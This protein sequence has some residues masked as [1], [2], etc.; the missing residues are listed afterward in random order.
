MLSRRK[1]FIC[2]VLK[3]IA[4]NNNIIVF[5][6]KAQIERMEMDIKALKS[7]NERVEALNEK[8]GGQTSAR[9]RVRTEEK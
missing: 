4:I 7:A 9:E 5:R 3:I 1:T 6:Y 8:L 2:A